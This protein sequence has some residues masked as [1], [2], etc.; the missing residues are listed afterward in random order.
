MSLSRECNRHSLG[1][2]PDTHGID[3]RLQ[4]SKVSILD[5]LYRS[6][7]F[8]VPVGSVEEDARMFLVPGI[9]V[10]QSHPYPVNAAEFPLQAAG[11]RALANTGGL[12]TDGFRNHAY[13]KIQLPRN[14]CCVQAARLR[15]E[16]CRLRRQECMGRR[17][18]I[19][20]LK[21]I[22][23][24]KCCVKVSLLYR[25]RLSGSGEQNM[26]AFIPTARPT[27]RCFGSKEYIAG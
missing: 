25:Q 21:I 2:L 15:V 3:K 12:A 24:R 22:G 27:G 18:V 7:V 11:V 14:P 6:T 16:Q 13:G 4:R 10:H 9:E 17:H 8:K 23:D 20:L 19:P 5:E 26:I 1:R